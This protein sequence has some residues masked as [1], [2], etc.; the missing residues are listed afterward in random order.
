MT[1]HVT[2][3]S[4]VAAVTGAPVGHSLSPVVHNAW[5]RAANID[6]VYVALPCRRGAFAELVEGL[7]GAVIRGLNVT[8]P[9][10]E[11][12]LALSDGASPRAR[13]AGAANLLVFDPDGAVMA[14]NTD[15][16]GML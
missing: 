15:G 7:R 4:S 1:W 6:A 10:K 11:E 5:L 2:A 3:R 8:A 16:E 12:A 14:D 13:A 9:F